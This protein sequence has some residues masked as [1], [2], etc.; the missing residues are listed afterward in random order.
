MA[1]NASKILWITMLLFVF[2]LP[3]SQFIS[4]RILVLLFVLSL[5]FG[6]GK[7]S[8][9][10]LFKYSWDILLYLLVL[11]L[12]ILYT[13]DKQTG[14]R[15]LETSFALLALPI[16]SSRIQGINRDRLNFILIFF[17][18]G[19]LTAGLICLINSVYTYLNNG[20]SNAF[21]YYDFTEVINSHPTYLA[22][23]LILA[24]TFG[25]YA[26][27]YEKIELP[28]WVILSFVLFCFPILLLTGGQSAFVSLLFV[29]SFFILKYLLGE[30]GKTESISFGVV[31]LMLIGILFINTGHHD[32]REQ[33]LNDSWDRF[34]LWRSGI[35]ANTDFLWGVGTG[36]Y[37]SV[38]NEYYRKTGQELF[39]R[40]SLNS[41]NQF[42]Q[43]FFSNGFL[44]LIAF[45]IIIIRP[46]YMAFRNN[47]Q[48]GILL[49]FPFLIYGMTEVFLGRY[50]GVVFFALLHQ[51]LV[52][53]YVNSKS[54]LIEIK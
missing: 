51:T 31:A 52:S 39:A 54:T 45:S 1:K 25:L 4:T 17:S 7:F 46:L 15:T 20:Q 24:I 12:G 35:F 34:E 9:S 2:M 19:V 23:Y 16:I 41:H 21:F 36:D 8:F 48:L 50:Q 28:M 14:F 5:F 13:S 22:Y 37:K 38:L 40:E 53:F 42:I 18:L 32:E 43:I 44:G 10:K 27:N 29:F 33:M 3:L 49:I 11:S 30:R 26:M 47:D 6:E